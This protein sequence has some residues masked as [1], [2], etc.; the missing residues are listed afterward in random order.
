MLKL[1]RRSLSLGLAS[2]T[3]ASA[4]P[5]TLRAAAPD[6]SLLAKLALH[7]AAFETMKTHASYAVDGKLEELAGDGSV[8]ST[9]QM[10]A[11]VVATGSAVHFDIVRYVEDGQDKTQEAKDKQRERASEP[12]KP[13]KHELHMPFLAS[14]QPRYAFELAETDPL[15]PERVRV[16]FA[17]KV[18]DE[19]TTEG[20]AWVDAAAGNVL[21]VGFKLSKP[22]SIVDYVHVTVV[23]GAPTSIG[24]APSKIAIDGQA[25]VLFLRKRFRAVATLSG[26]LITP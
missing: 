7:A 11:A 1:T 4:L 17:P 5:R 21:S 24:P 18:K 26:H 3:A 25:G 8:S 2:V 15:D 10:T 22:P 13:D 20:S 23:F 12:K 16:S 19:D 6:P 14:E 9:K